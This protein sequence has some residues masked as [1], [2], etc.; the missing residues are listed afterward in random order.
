MAG[1]YCRITALL[2]AVAMLFSVCITAEVSAEYSAVLTITFTG[3]EA[4]KAGFAQ[5]TLT[6]FPKSGSSAS[7]YYL[8][9]YTDSNGVLKDYDQLGFAPITGTKAICKISD[10]MMIPQGATGIAAF[11]SSNWFLDNPPAIGDA[12]A[13]AEIPQ[14][15]RLTLGTPETKFGA[16]S[17]VHMNYEGYSRGA[18]SKWAKALEF[19]SSWDAEHII[20]TG[21][22]TGD[23]GEN[24]DLEA[25]YAKYKE[26]LNNSSFPADKVYEGIGNHG[27]TPADAPL[28]DKYLGGSD[29]VHPYT[30]SPYYHVLIKGDAEERDNLYIFMAQEITAAGQSSTCDNFSKTQIDWL[31][32]LLKTYYN[33]NTNIF[34]TEHAPFLNYGAGDRKG[35]GYTST[36]TFSDS[37]PQTMRLKGLLSTYKDVIVM[38]GHTHVS[39]YDNVNYSDE[40][41]E[42]ARTVHV[43]STC[44]P[45]GYGNSSVYTRNT[46][47]RY[48]VSTTY[49]SEGYTVEI[50][51]D[52][53]VYTGYNLSTGK[54]IPAA[55]I[56][57]P[58]KA[59]GGAPRPVT[60]IL[61]PDK[62]FEGSGTASDPY[63]IADAEDF[64]L[65]T[66]GFNAST[67]T[68]ESEMYGYGK[69][70]LQVADIDM[71]NYDGY[72]GTY[73]NGNAKC[74][75][76]GSYNGNG[77]TLRV[78]INADGQRSVF[79]Y[80]YGLIY[81][82]RIEGSIVAEESA[83]PIRTNR[84]GIVNCIFDLDLYA[85]KANGV[86]YTNYNYVYNVYTCG[87]A[88]GA[89]PNGA[90]MGA[91]STDVINLYY[92]R[93]TSA[94][95]EVL[96]DYGVKSNSV[97]DIAS[98][99]NSR[100]SASY[101]AIA[102]KIG[103][104]T[105]KNVY[106][107]KGTLT[108]V[109]GSS[110]PIIPE[111]SEMLWLTHF[112]NSTVEGAG[113][114]FTEAYSGAAWWLHVAFAP[115][116]GS[117]AYKI[118][119]IS[120]GLSAGNGKALAIPEGGFVW[121]ANYGNDYPAIYERDPV[122]NSW[123]ANT[124][125][126]TSTNC[127][128]MITRALSWKVGDMFLFSGLDL[129]SKTVP[130]ATSDLVWYS[131]GYVCTAY[132]TPYVPALSGDVNLDE[133]V[134][135]FDYLM[136]K[137]ICLNLF[138]PTDDEFKRADV[139]ADGSV[140]VFDYLTVKT[141]C[142]SN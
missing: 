29:E 131:E 81:N 119:E 69:H 56:I 141:M 15:K 14:S 10:G 11:E 73:A 67:S 82:L 142:F 101:T 64:M 77:H 49:G 16:V 98:V 120:N 75:F 45:C 32:N 93:T 132:I 27:N 86:C 84:G 4:E 35:G 105:L 70:F 57:M 58:I 138:V 91:S 140:D 66:N 139:T 5:S 34:I 112:G 76:A 52:Y 117:D 108:F 90:I 26:I 38:S 43:G 134:D 127:S 42:F 50:Y 96:S 60:E 40:Y 30:N 65:F 107:S 59:Y 53:I 130:T 137:S 46:D 39:L 78:D 135:I 80:N 103:S 97:S 126:Y 113:S 55:S 92:Y 22:M 129:A 1:K 122:N 106:A 74:H 41:N 68:T 123:C 36:V 12:V 71:S 24:P 87:K 2:M 85:N 79:P 21:D 44:Q 28:M 136:I 111:G 104:R 62:A 17:D 25:Q 100:T 51:S 37:Y 8:F 125:D 63:I 7:G 94:G 72:I 48:E 3:D 61:T 19:F 124:P 20:V 31:E 47:G 115:V 128:S 23:R 110:S 102:S 114:V 6:L 133:T 109:S 9:Y 13:R 95:A 121:A 88:S 54:K 18:Y 89:T 33:G 118:V 99:F 83:Q 116:E